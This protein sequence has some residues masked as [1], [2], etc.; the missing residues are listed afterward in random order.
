MGRGH[1]TMRDSRQSPRITY[2][3]IPKV[4]RER[5]INNFN[6]TIIVIDSFVLTW[7]RFQ[8]TCLLTFRERIVAKSVV[9]GDPGL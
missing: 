6:V 1:F 2:W 4:E 5:I 3:I 7:A 9:Y 8:V